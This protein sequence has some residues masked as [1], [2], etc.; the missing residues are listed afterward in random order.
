MYLIFFDEVKVQPDYPHYH[1]GAI[2]IE[3]NHLKEI[4]SE[5]NAISKLVFDEIELKKETEF[6]AHNIYH[7]KEQFKN[8][9][10]VQFRINTLIDL[11]KILSKPCVNLIHIQINTTKLYNPFYAAD[12]AFMFF[13][14]KAESLMQKEKSLGLLIGDR[15][16]DSVTNR[17]SVAL[18]HYRSKGTEYE[19]RKQLH[20]LFESVHFTPSHLSRFLQLADVYSWICQFKNK[21][22]NDRNSLKFS[23]FFIQL[24][25]INLFPAKWKEWPSK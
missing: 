24:D 10:D 17:Y 5:V 4:E 18:S 12:Y 20:Y 16:N 23:D 11:L 21:Y 22:K 19:F 13:C 2:C 14:E 1:I 7:K 6:R 9:P 3:E 8:K 15:E 25:E